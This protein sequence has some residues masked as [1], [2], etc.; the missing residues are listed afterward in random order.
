MPRLRRQDV[1]HG[2]DIAFHAGDL[3]ET[4]DFAG[5]VAEA[6]DLNDHINRRSNLPANG[7]VGNAQLDMATMVS[8]RLRASRGVF[9]WMVV[10]EPSWPVFMAC[11]MSAPLR[12]EPHQR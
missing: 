11:S 2:D 12:R 1:L 3:R 9:A 10:I 8:K 6:A 4:D 5:T 7:V